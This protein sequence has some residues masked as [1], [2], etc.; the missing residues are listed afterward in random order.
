MAPKIC[1]LFTQAEPLE[2][3]YLYSQVSKGGKPNSSLTLGILFCPEVSSF[4]WTPGDAEVNQRQNH[5]SV[6]CCFLD[7]EGELPLTLGF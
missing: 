5:A 1:S 6:P 3:L 2:E 7:S 4:F